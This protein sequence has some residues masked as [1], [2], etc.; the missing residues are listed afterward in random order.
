MF[1][2]KLALT[3]SIL[4]CNKQKAAGQYVGHGCVETC[5]KTFQI[6]YLVLICVDHNL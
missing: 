5:T 4:L 2:R 1:V 3:L 6:Q